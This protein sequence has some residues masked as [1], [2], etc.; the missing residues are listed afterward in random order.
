MVFYLPPSREKNDLKALIEKHG[1]LVTDMHE[2]FTYQIAPLNEEV[3]K[4]NYFLGDVYYA[5]WI[6]DS[7]KN[8]E[9]LDKDQYFAFS[10]NVAHMKRM[11]FNCRQ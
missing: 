11:T 4:S 7:A 6:V 5:H 3:K 8:G 2:C 9:L 1:G 10:P